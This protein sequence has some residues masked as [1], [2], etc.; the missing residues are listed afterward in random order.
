MCTR[1][2][3]VVTTISITADRASMRIDQL[4]LEVAHVDERQQ[5]T[6]K[7]SMCPQV[8]WLNVYQLRPQ[9]RSSAPVVIACEATSPMRR[10]NRPA[11]IAATSGAK[12]IMVTS[13]CMTSLSPSSCWRRQPRCRRGFGRR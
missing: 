9:A 5:V 3:T 4:G 10:P 11:M 2:E 7:A 13:V 8:H 6:V 12:T 1:A